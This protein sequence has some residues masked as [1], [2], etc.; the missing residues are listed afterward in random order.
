MS[1]RSR[2]LAA[3]SPNERVNAVVSLTE[4]RSNRNGPKLDLP[5]PTA[6]ASRQPKSFNESKINNNPAPPPPPPG[7]PPPKKSGRRST[8]L[9]KSSRTADD[10]VEV[11]ETVSFRGSRSS[12]SLNSQKSDEM[13]RYK[14]GGSQSFNSQSSKVERTPSAPSNPLSPPSSFGRNSSHLSAS[15]GPDSPAKSTASGEVWSPKDEIKPGNVAKFRNMLWGGESSSPREGGTA[16]KPREQGQKLNRGG[17]KKTFKE[18]KEEEEGGS[19]DNE[20]TTQRYQKQSPGPNNIQ[21]NAPNTQRAPPSTPPRP[22]ASRNYNNYNSPNRGRISTRSPSPPKYKLNAPPSLKIGGRDKVAPPTR[23]LKQ[24]PEKSPVKVRNGGSDSVNSNNSSPLR[25][26]ASGLNLAPIDTSFGVGGSGK[27]RNR[28]DINTDGSS[29]T[30]LPPSGSNSRSKSNDAR[31]ETLTLLGAS[32]SPADTDGNNK[33]PFA[34]EEEDKY[35]LSPETAPTV[36]SSV[37]NASVEAAPPTPMINPPGVITITAFKRP[38]VKVG[39]VFSR[40]SRSSPDVCVISRIIPD[41]IFSSHEHRFAREESG[42][43]LKGAEVI[44]V[45]GIPVREPRHAAELVAGCANEVMLTI[46]RV[47]NFNSQNR[48]TNTESIN[49]ELDPTSELAPIS[50][51]EPVHKMNEGPNKTDDD[52]LIIPEEK[53]KDGCDDIQLEQS[54]N[55]SDKQRSTKSQD[56]IQRRRQIAQAMI[57]SSEMVE[58]HVPSHKA[59]SQQDD[60]VKQSS[61]NYG[62]SSIQQRRLA[63]L[64][65]YQSQEMVADNVDDARLGTIDTNIPSKAFDPIS[66]FTC[67][68]DPFGDNVSVATTNVTTSSD[69]TQRMGSNNIKE[70]FGDTFPQTNDIPLKSPQAQR[71]KERAIQRIANSSSVSRSAKA[72]PS[73]VSTSATSPTALRSPVSN[74][75][76]ILS[77]LPAQPASQTRVIKPDD[78][79]VAAASTAA[80]SVAASAATSTAAVSESSGESRGSRSLF[81]KKK[82][83]STGSLLAETAPVKRKSSIFGVANLI[84]KVNV[85]LSWIEACYITNALFLTTFFFT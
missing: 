30:S 31:A 63:A 8:S 44:A 6:V 45:N 83:Q 57:T 40:R 53:N 82:K 10:N 72:P 36:S 78:E 59:D 49:E 55:L 26:R 39:M 67:N 79:S 76:K 33:F 28:S 9:G 60:E 65:M 7:P 81:G 71:R 66:S 18:E 52:E 12:T 11:K 42:G 75:N 70:F 85:C 1:A 84:R 27:S 21:P 41:S 80:S 2:Y 25:E 3:I 24:R 62:A 15:S 5:S 51:G 23:M 47:S 17:N 73:A 22:S 68:N 48:S 19:A 50:Q 43:T 58:D 56:I 64:Q 61:L 77:N 37:A 29:V 34:L 32:P 38:D 46:K 35:A 20:G 54:Q 69:A 74:D 16:L 14:V 13:D 4:P